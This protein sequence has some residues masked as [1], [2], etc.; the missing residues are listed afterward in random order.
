MGAWLKVNGESIYGTTAGPFSY[1]SWG[2][3]TRK[4]DLLYLH[5]TDW[6]EN[7]KL[8]VPLSKQGCE[9]GS[10]GTTRR[11]LAIKSRR[12]ER[13][14]IDL[15]DKG[16]DPVASVIILKLDEEPVVMPM[17]SEG[18]KITASSRTSRSS[19]SAML[20]MEQVVRSGNLQIPQVKATWNLIWERLPG[21][22]QSDWMNR[23]GG[24]AT[25]KTSAWK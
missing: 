4:G 25:G 20:R 24:H 6:P 22:M 3:A 18:K 7:D 10:S 9:C 14:V 21:S 1:L 5:V 13:M 8:N 2:A 17:A 19:G 23:T 12:S 15:P 16:P 11:V